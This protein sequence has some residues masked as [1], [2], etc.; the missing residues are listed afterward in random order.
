[1]T[2]IAPFSK[3]NSRAIAVLAGCLFLST[4]Y[5]E[6]PRSGLS[7]DFSHGPLKVSENR[8]FIVHEDGTPFFYLGDTAWELFHRLTRE[9]AERYLENRR[10]KGFTV[11]Q[12]VVL[13]ELDGLET[14][15]AYGDKPL[16]NNN[17]AQPNEAYFKHVDFIVN[18]AKEKGI[19]IGMLPTWGDKVTKAWGKGPVVFNP[20]NARIYGRFLGQRYRIQPNIIWILG[21]D[22]VADGA[23][24]IWRAMAQGIQ[25]GDGGIHLITYHPQGGQSSS[26]WFHEDEWLAFNMLQSG[27]DRFDNPNYRMITADYNREPVKP[28]FDGEPRY[29][30]HPVNWK[31]EN[32]W[33]NDFDVRQAAY[34]ALFAGAFG[35]TYGCH[36]IWQMMAPGRAPISSARNNWYDVLDLP[37]AWDMMHVRHLMESRP[38]LSRV[39][40]QS[41]IAEGQSEGAGHVQATRG[42]GY[43][44]VYIP[45]GTPVTIQLGKISGGKVMAWWYDPRK[46]TAS[47]IDSF[48]DSGTRRFDPPGPEKRGND[49]VL[50]LDDASQNFPAPGQAGK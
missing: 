50:V 13:A 44:F 34:W 43:A 22:R 33:F 9:E 5:A 7:V 12:A 41:L 39:P 47:L 29:E 46:G 26:K 30:D 31:A 15:N 42:D 21:G 17:P 35:H 24:E 19:F 2:R 6:T 16:L 1:M 8:R 14:P 11:I 23:E 27:H 10:Q 18:K 20:E 28:C 36:D 32:G 48:A 38:F 49:W 37:G 40:D 25:E 3:I 45:A 4:A